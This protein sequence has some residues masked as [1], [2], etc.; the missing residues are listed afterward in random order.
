MYTDLQIGDRVTIQDAGHEFSGH[1][2]TIIVMR[3]PSLRLSAKERSD[4]N[5]LQQRIRNEAS[6]DVQVDD[7]S[8]VNAQM[9][10]LSRLDSNY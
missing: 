3:Y 6:V 5:L 2:G 4:P 7:G 8:I 10:C 9:R 1:T